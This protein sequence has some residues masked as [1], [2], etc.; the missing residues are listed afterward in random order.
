M[1]ARL[2]MFA[3]MRT[4]VDVSGRRIA[5]YRGFDAPGAGVP[6]V[7]LPGAGLVGLDYW[8][9]AGRDTVLY[10]RCGTGWS[11]AVALP[12]SAADVATE[13]HDAIGPGPWVLVAHSIGAIYARRFAQLYPESVR[14]LLLIDPGHEDLFDYLPPAAVELNSALKPDPAQLPDL[15]AAQLSA[16][17]EAYAR[18]FAAWPTAVR[19]ELIDHHLTHWR[20]A[21]YEAENLESAVYP[22]LRAGGPVPDVPTTVLTAGAGNPAW[23]S[24][25]DAA[26]VQQALDGIRKLHE[27]IAAGSSR[28][29]HIVVDGATHQFLHI[30]HPGV[31]IDALRELAQA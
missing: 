27:T 15:T 19:D 23:S 17:R 7:V 4:F 30:E 29:R 9:I 5:R 20:T 21:L 8:P 13:L 2:L 28:G 11:S 18:L 31:V 12:R 26:L 24:V 14:G 1:F 25:G 6:A 10:D 16:A 3:D 22:E